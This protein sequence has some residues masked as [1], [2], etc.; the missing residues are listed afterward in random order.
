[1]WKDYYGKAAS[2]REWEENYYVRKAVGT[3]KLPG[4]LVSTCKDSGML[5]LGWLIQNP[6]RHGDRKV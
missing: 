4:R 6:C 3:G 2:E 5:W 1:M